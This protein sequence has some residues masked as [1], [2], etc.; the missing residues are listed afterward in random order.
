MKSNYLIIMYTP[1]FKT[2]LETLMR[3]SHSAVVIVMVP[4][5]NRV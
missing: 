2:V 5:V 3:I 4:P 1:S